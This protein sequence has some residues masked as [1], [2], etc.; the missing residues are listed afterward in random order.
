MPASS[1]RPTA[2]PR[3]ERP[4]VVDAGAQRVR[5]MRQAADRRVGDV[6]RVG[7]RGLAA[8]GLQMLVRNALA[9]A[10]SFEI[11]RRWHANGLPVFAP[12]TT[13]LTIQGTILGTLGMA[14]QRVIGTVIGVAVATAFVNAAGLHL[15]SLAVAMF[16]S[17]LLARSLPTGLSGQLQVPLAVLLVMVAGP[18]DDAYGVW[19]SID[20]LL[21]GVIG[22][23]AVLVFP[24][25]VRL[26]PTQ[27]ALDAWALTLHD[28]LARI[29]ADL[30]R[31]PRK[32]PLRERHDYLINSRSLHEPLAAARDALSAVTEALRLNPWAKRYVDEI[33]RLDQ[34]Q[35]R[36]ERATLQVRGLSYSI[37]KLY[38]RGLTPRLPRERLAL[39]LRQ[40]AAVLLRSDAGGSVDLLSGRLRNAVDEAIH[41]LSVMPGVRLPGMLDSVGI[42]TRIEQLRRELSGL[43]VVLAFDDEAGRAME[44]EF[45]D[46]EVPDDA[47]RMSDADGEP[48]DARRRGRE[49]GQ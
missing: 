22:V 35:V 36:L 34:R 21:G 8:G 46:D 20:T 14:A 44:L 26:A 9:C 30:E 3:A 5:A 7:N 19:R 25:R 39:L 11:A 4:A 48:D 43:P 17:L 2:R 32:L 18:A 13:V 40:L 33:A 24:P 27:Q 41:D 23:A 1:W 10:V 49:T 6:L 47:V 29:A 15:W 42:L 37:D 38:D 45:D 28:Q 12:V 31:E 16:A